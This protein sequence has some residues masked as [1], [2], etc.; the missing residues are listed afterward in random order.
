MALVFR[1][2][3]TVGPGST[4]AGQWMPLDIIDRRLKDFRIF[5]HGERPKTML[6]QSREY[7][8][9]IVIDVTEDD[10]EP[11][12]ERFPR[13]GFYRVVGL[14]PRNAEFLFERI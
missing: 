1:S 9:H 3:G 8:T 14:R 12:P 2:R 10:S 11:R 13:P 6:P 4:D 7:F 5:C